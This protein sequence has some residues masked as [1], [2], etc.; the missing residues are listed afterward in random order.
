MRIGI[1]GFFRIGRLA[2]RALQRHP[3]LQLVHVNHVV[4]DSLTHAHLLAFD[5]IHRHWDTPVSANDNQLVIN[6]RSVT[7]LTKN[8]RKCKFRRM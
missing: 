5:S 3:E 7:D 8:D 2:I 1:N 6:G 4:G